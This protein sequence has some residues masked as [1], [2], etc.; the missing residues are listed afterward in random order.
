MWPSSGCYTY[1]SILSFAFDIASH[2]T[3]LKILSA[4]G[5]FDGF[6]SWFGSCLSNRQTYARISGIILLPFAVLFGDPQG[7]V[8][9]HVLLNIII[10]NLRIFIKLLLL[11]ILGV[12]S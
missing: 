12:W 1:V 6:A 11:S 5:R 4:V 7:F 10:N 2:F 8:L 3:L 9:G